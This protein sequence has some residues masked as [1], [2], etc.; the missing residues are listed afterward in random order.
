VVTGGAFYRSYDNVTYTD[1]SYPA[2]VS[3]F[4]MDRFEITVGRFRK[5]V[6]A[7]YGTQLNPPADGSGAN[8]NLAGSGWQ[9]GWN[10]WLPPDKA[11]LTLR[12]K[13][14]SAQPTW[15]DGAGSNED[16]PIDCI[17]WY[18][19]FAFCIWDG[20]RLPTEAEWNY[21]ASGGSEQRVYP[22]SSPP[23]SSTLDCN[24]AN[25]QEPQCCV[26]SCSTN[27]VGSESPQG[28]GKWGQADLTGNV[29]EWNLDWYATYSNP[30]NDCANISNPSEP[31][32]R[33]IRGGDSF[34]TASTELSSYRSYLAMHLSGPV[35]GARCVRP[36]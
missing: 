8:P 21:A 22:W 13:H 35:L 19:A 5:F 18:E 33:V 23:G 15:T 10:G 25:C 12:L 36:P 24:H 2:T 11:M 1:K 6:E 4:R 28:D 7:G 17:D 29:G 34:G 31:E 27:D 32:A 26:Y 9:S 20:G 14:C 16:R 30:C 3:D